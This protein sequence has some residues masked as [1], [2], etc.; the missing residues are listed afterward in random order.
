[1]FWFCR[2]TSR[3]HA[4][5]G[6][7]QELRRWEDHHGRLL[8]RSMQKDSH[9]RLLALLL[10]E[11]TRG[12]LLARLQREHRHG[13]H[14]L[15]MQQLQLLKTSLSREDSSLVAEGSARSARIGLGCD[16][17]KVSAAHAVL[18]LKI[19]RL[20]L[21][22]RVQRLQLRSQPTPMTVRRTSMPHVSWLRFSLIA[23]SVASR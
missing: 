3:P 12:R 19:L 9:G 4:A 2:F 16:A 17:A 11:N 22:P 6:R 10:L 8:I 20:P 15:R 14:H 23:M 5:R 7:Q 13:A 21:L 1:M 18:L